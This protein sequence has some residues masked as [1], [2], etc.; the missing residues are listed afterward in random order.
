MATLFSELSIKG[1][2]SKNRIVLPPMVCFYEEHGNGFVTDKNIN[3]YKEKAFGG[4]GIIIVEATC[5]NPS[6]KLHSCQLGI[7][8][9]KFVDGLKKIADVIHEGGALAFIQIH[10]AGIKTPQNVCENPMAP[11]DFDIKGRKAHGMSQKEIDETIEEFKNA[12][13]R[14]E[15]AGFD[16]I[17]L[18]GCHAYLISQ[19]LSP[20]VNLRDDEYG[21]QKEKFGVDVIKAVKSVVSDKFIVG[22]RTSGNDPDLKTSVEYAQAFVKAGADYLHVSTGYINDIPADMVID[23]SKPYNWIA[24]LGIEIKKHVDVPVMCVNGIKTPEQ[25]K[26]IIENDLADFVAIGKAQIV[27]TNWANKVAENKEIDECLGCA[28]CTLFLNI[29]T[30]NKKRNG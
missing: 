8:D 23:E 30:C 13:I 10:H 21:K 2:I 7:W 6:G 1:N 14:A 3:H 15:K 27:D 17:E 9:D 5:I 19:F 28:K 16:G 22:I 18:H 12:A 4:S 25:A 26:Y 24:Q 11:S 20:K 29:E